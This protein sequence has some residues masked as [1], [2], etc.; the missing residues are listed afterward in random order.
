MIKANCRLAKAVDG[1]LHAQIASCHV[2][3]RELVGVIERFGLAT[4][5]K[6]V[7]RMFDH[8]EHVVRE[9]IQKVPDG[10]YRAAC[11]IDNN[12]IDET[13]IHFDVVVTIEGSNARF[14]FSQAPD[15]H[16]GPTNCPMPSTVCT[17][18][19]TLAILAGNDR[20]TPNEGHFRP[21]E[22]VTRPGSMFHP[23]A[24]Q[25]CYLYGWP[26][27]GAMEGIFEA[28]AKATGGRVP[29]GSAGG[30]VGW[31]Y[32]GTS[33]DTGEGFI[34]AAIL[35]VGHGASASADGGTMFV[36]ALAH[37]QSDSPELQEAKLP[38]LFEKW[39]FTPDS[40]GPGQYR[41]GCGWEVYFT[42]RSNVL[43]ISGMEATKVPGW[44]QKG[45]L[46]GTANRFEIDFPDGHVETLRKATDFPV[47]AG[48]RLR[49]YCG[50]GGGYGAP[51]ERDPS[52]V[53]RDLLEGFITDEHARKFYSHAL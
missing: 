23:V 50:G 31:Q 17:A 20:E 36:G 3:A 7:E 19:I 30:L 42:V 1:D 32:Y 47:P 25:P 44:A 22:V 33:Q 41:G 21:L 35:P 15:A 18:R 26:I 8:G 5:E 34:S 16:R 13:P 48:S 9:F 2:G 49:L 4:F 12:G 51:V 53:R 37:A 10:I 52:A 46:S 43:L 28:F 29:S 39:E 11:H 40:A 24:P 38:V 27:L 6:C 14:D 45:G